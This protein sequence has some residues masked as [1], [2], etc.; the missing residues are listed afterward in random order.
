MMIA[1]VFSVYYVCIAQRL[2]KAKQQRPGADERVA[3]RT[4]KKPKTTVSQ[5]YIVYSVTSQ[6]EYN[7]H[8]ITCFPF[9]KCFFKNQV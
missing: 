6:H 2:G 9:M 8:I 3:D 5:L 7:N 4:L 1:V